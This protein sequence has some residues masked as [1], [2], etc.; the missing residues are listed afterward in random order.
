MCNHLKSVVAVNVHTSHALPPAFLEEIVR[1][2][3]GYLCQMNWPNMI[4]FIDWLALLPIQILGSAK[5]V[6]NNQR[7]RH[8]DKPHSPAVLLWFHGSV[9]SGTPAPVITRLVKELVWLEADVAP[10]K[11][12]TSS[13]LLYLLSRANG[14]RVAEGISSV[15]LSGP[16]RLANTPIE[17]TT[18]EQG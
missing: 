10:S 6:G 7:T 12:S 1:S 14:S 2:S 8:G 11:L 3:F 4:S 17:A 16:L 5:T 15:D 18:G 9:N 13:H